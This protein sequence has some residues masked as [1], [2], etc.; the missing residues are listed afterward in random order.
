MMAINNRL[1]GVKQNI[2]N[3]FNSKGDRSKLV[4]KNAFISVGLK[5]FSVLIG[6][7]LM[8]MYLHYFGKDSILGVWLTLISVLNWIFTFD[9]GIGNGL[10]NHLVYALA[11]QDDELARTYIASAYFSL[12]GICG[13]IIVGLLIAFPNVDCNRV[14]NVSTEILN[15]EELNYGVMILLIGI[16]MQ[17]VLKSINA[18]LFALQKAAVPSLLNLISNILLLLYMAT[19]VH[20]GKSGHIINLAYFYIVATNG[21]LL[22]T[23]IVIFRG[24]LKHCRPSIH[25][26][27]KEK[28]KEVVSLGFA[29]LW[30]QVMG[31]MISSTNRFLI[32]S[33]IAPQEVVS[34]EVYY[35]VFGL[36]N[37]LLII[38]ITPVW[39]AVTD[40]VAKGD[41][42]WIIKL[43]D[44]VYTLFGLAILAVF[45]VFLGSKVII[46]YWMGPEYILENMKFPV[47]MALFIVIYIWSGINANIVAGLN[48]LNVALIF[49][50]IGAIM[51]IPLAYLFTR[52]EATWF[53][54]VLANSL[55]LLPYCIIET[56]DTNRL[57][58]KKL[59]EEEYV[60][61]TEKKRIIM[62]I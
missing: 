8:P 19:M 20:L 57:L 58:K 7:L 11:H 3:R 42:Q 48:K 12:S 49:L 40:A 16:M 13:L 60:K 31:M 9:L 25:Y 29:F 62:D 34:Y 35:K 15:P 32:A 44:K 1:C 56:I 45:G 55:S 6:L 21:P 53:A 51:N 36:V 59:K 38:A 33:F 54:I 14:F 61:E 47:M 43:K 50:S 10:R 46:T 17:F 22:I 39:S 28:I 37:M 2:I 5:G 24:A 18:I 27:K 23:T 41:Y 4:I 30:L 26:V 52:Y